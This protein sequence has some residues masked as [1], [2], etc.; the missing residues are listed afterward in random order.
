MHKPDFGLLAWLLEEL[1]S[2][3]YFI[4][5]IDAREFDLWSSSGSHSSVELTAWPP[6]STV[7]ALFKVSIRTKQIKRS[8]SPWHDRFAAAQVWSQTMKDSSANLPHF[9]LS[10]LLMFKCASCLNE[11]FPTP[12]R[13]NINLFTVHVLG[14]K[15][16]ILATYPYSY[17]PG[18]AP[19][20]EMHH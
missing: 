5:R 11:C 6:G 15:N 16:S 12:S 3:S 18:N 10:A 19:P 14:K 2:D 4:G 1:T 17:T 8:R 7:P 9:V 13:F 20:R